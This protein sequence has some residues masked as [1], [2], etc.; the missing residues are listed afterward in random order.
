M[1]SL[2]KKANTYRL[3]KITTSEDLGCG[4]STLIDFGNKV[5]VAGHYYSGPKT[6]SYYGAVYEHTTADKS[7]EGEI[8]LTAISDEMFEDAGHALQ[9]AMSH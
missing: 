2:E 7:C 8:K 3:P 9:W 5:L 6:N 1:A 4:W